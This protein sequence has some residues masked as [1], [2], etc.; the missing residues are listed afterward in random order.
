[1]ASLDDALALWRRGLSVIPVPLPRP[2][3]PRNRPGDGKTPSIAW[4]QFQRR[5]AT[6]AELRGWLAQ[7]SNIG[8]VCGA[9]SG[10][11]VIDGDS[12]EALRWLTRRLPY[13]PWQVQTARGYHLYLRAPGTPV[14]NRARIDTGDGRLAIDVRG[15]GG[16]VVAPGSIHASGHVYVEAGDW[17]AQIAVLPIF[18]PRWLADAQPR[19]AQPAHPNKW[20][21]GTAP[22]R[23]RRYLRRLP[24]PEI[25]CG[26][27]AATLYAACRGVRGFALDAHV[28][29]DLLDEWA[30]GRPGWDRQ[31][32]AQ[33]VAN[34][35]RF[36]TE[37]IGGLL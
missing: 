14:R 28:A 15:D 11:I 12:P 21:A 31:W 1:M 26:S 32:L 36:G 25:G 3:V 5:R 9:I 17:R 33:K 34:A 4:G 13:T 24:R 37:P 29:V 35:V 18:D 30:G 22:E 7:P 8:I 19:G 2:G 27:D 20:P 6:E 16:F 23:F 10:V